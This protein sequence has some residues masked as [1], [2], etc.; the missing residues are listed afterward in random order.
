LE[1]WWADLKARSANASLP[2]M[3]AI[4]TVLETA[5][6][7]AHVVAGDEFVRGH[8]FVSFERVRQAQRGACFS[9]IDMS[10]IDPDDRCAAPQTKWSGSE[11]SKQSIAK[12]ADLNHRDALS[13][14]RNI[15][16]SLTILLRARGCSAPESVLAEVACIQ[17]TKYL[18]GTRQHRWRCDHW[19]PTTTRTDARTIGFLQNAVVRSRPV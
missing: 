11:N 14:A 12:L 17:A 13:R 5:R 4:A 15:S 6:P 9:F 1:R 19:H 7:R 18:N 3:A 16:R 10:N 8:V 2:G